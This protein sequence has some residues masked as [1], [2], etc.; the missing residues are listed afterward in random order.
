MNCKNWNF[1]LKLWVAFKYFIIIY[2]FQESKLNNA[3]YKD[4]IKE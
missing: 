3:T 4:I 1:I 2:I